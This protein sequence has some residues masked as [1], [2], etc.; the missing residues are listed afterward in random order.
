M[1]SSVR[2]KLSQQFLEQQ[3]FLKQQIKVPFL[4]SMVSN[5][6]APLELARELFNIRRQSAAL[7]E[8][9]EYKHRMHALLETAK[10]KVPKDICPKCSSTKFTRF[11]IHRSPM[12][13]GY[14]QCS[15][16]EKHEWIPGSKVLAISAKDFEYNCCGDD[17]EQR[18]IR[19]VGGDKAYLD[20]VVKEAQLQVEIMEN[21]I[22]RLKNA[23]RAATTTPTTINTIVT[24]A[25]TFQSSS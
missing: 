21:E 23:I 13:E 11:A 12:C 1:P 25:A 15:M 5:E 14:N 22:Q 10:E 18:T 7:R 19:Q 20:L 3:Q 8:T 9:T 2:Q 6:V 4:F 16:D 24:T 17:Q